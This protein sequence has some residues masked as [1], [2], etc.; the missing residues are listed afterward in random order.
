MN[1]TNMPYDKAIEETAKTT[2]R[3]LDIVQSMTPAVADAYGFLIG[4]R[5]SAARER[6]LDKLSRETKKI[7]YDRN[8][9][10]TQPLPEQI[11]IPL[12]EAAQ[13]ETRSEL[14]DV[15]ATMLANAMDPKFA[16]NV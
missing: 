12:L 3:V 1:E 16:S 9:E 10:E 5:I 15:F 8:V 11:A 2:G 14:Q 6:Q 13:G 4:D 7:L